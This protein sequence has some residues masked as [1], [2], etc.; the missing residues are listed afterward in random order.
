MIVGMCHGVFD[1]MHFG[2]IRHLRT[3]KSKCDRLVVSV[4]ADRFVNKGPTRPVFPLEYR[5]EVLAAVSLVDEVVAS[6]TP[7]SVPN[8]QRFKPKFYF[9]HV[10]Y[11]G[12]T[13]PGFLEEAR[14]CQENGIEIVFTEGEQ[15]SSTKALQRFLLAV[16]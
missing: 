15:G 3:A 11:R 7:S 8:L 13:H 9:K 6:E 2:H 12:S 1:L 4:T 14:F 10:E 5:M 16:Q